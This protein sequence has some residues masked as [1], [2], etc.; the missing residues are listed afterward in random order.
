MPESIT[1][2]IKENGPYLISVEDAASVIIVDAAGVRHVPTPGKA[3]A[4]CRCGQSMHKPFCDKTHRTVGFHGS[5]IA[6][7][8]QPNAGPSTPMPAASTPDGLSAPAATTSASTESAETRR[9][10]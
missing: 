4:L 7:D 5:L 2:K 3:I 9:A 10:P 8:D 6:P 1:I